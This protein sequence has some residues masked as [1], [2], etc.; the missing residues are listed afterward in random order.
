MVV[1]PR[2]ALLSLKR[3]TRTLSHDLRGALN[4]IKIYAFGLARIGP[5][6]LISVTVIQFIH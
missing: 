3:D 1:G 6:L 2:V 5:S 4:S